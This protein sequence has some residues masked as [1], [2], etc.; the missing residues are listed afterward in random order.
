M[1]RVLRDEPGD[2]DEAEFADVGAGADL[3]AAGPIVDN[4][5]AGRQRANADLP[6]GGAAD[7]TEGLMTSNLGSAATDKVVQ[8][9]TGPS[10]VNAG[11]GALTQGEPDLAGLVDA[12][13]VRAQNVTA[14]MAERA[15]GVKYP[16]V[17][18]YCEKIVND[19]KEKF[20]TF[21]GHVEM[22]IEL[23]QS[24]DRLEE[25]QDRLEVYVDATMEMLDGNRGD[26]GDGMFYGGGYE[27][28]FGPVKQGGKNFIQVAKVTFQIEVNRN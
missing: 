3:G 9:I 1:E 26:W 5:T 2:D 13:Q 15:L 21:S 22:A 18:V 19:L 20:Q 4:G 10:G 16:A 8:R 6:A 17:N 7:D 24:Q 28:A 25:I 23:R 27:V 14:D 11:I 12:S